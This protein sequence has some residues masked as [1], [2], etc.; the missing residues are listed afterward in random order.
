MSS[1]SPL[2]SFSGVGAL[3][4]LCF[5][6]WYPCPL[7]PL[8]LPLYLPYPLPP[9]PVPLPPDTRVDSVSAL[10]LSDDVVLLAGGLTTKGGPVLLAM[11]EELSCGDGM[12]L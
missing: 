10:S 5:A 9:Q 7:F 4:F 2:N 11:V 12:L 1:V 6:V 8:S 3:F